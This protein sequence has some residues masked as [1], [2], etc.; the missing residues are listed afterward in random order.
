MTM[1]KT[2]RRLWDFKLAVLLL[3][4]ALSNL[5]S[6]MPGGYDT[7]DLECES[8]VEE[9][10]QILFTPESV[11]IFEGER[12]TVAARYTGSGSAGWSFKTFPGDWMIRSFSLSPETGKSTTISLEARDPVIAPAP[13]IED[14][15]L[16]LRAIP[17]DKPAEEKARWLSIRTVRPPI[18]KRAPPDA[19]V[20]GSAGVFRETFDYGLEFGGNQPFGKWTFSVDLVNGAYGPWVQNLSI[21]PLDE[22]RARVTF[23]VLGT[24]PNGRC[25][26]VNDMGQPVCDNFT[27]ETVEDPDCG[28]LSGIRLRVTARW[29]ERGRQISLD[30]AEFFLWSS[31]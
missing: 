26:R 30:D 10:G 12:T 21:A 13:G 7:A 11:Q 9:D 2:I 15:K 19:Y 31:R 25:L 8:C 22:F 6:S 18:V 17:L 4:L 24:M 20:E 16:Y 1:K 23:Q 28:C 14:T 29:A 27:P 5:G 3:V